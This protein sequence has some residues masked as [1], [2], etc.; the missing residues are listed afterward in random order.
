MPHYED[1]TP[2]QLGD[3]V[4]GKPYNTPYEVVGPV[5]S[6]TPDVEAC[7]CQVAFA[8]AD[9]TKPG[10]ILIRTVTDYGETRAF[11]KVYP[12]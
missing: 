2:A 8:V 3:I 6:I 9:T 11:K 7:N 1:G 4:Q 12:T 5:V 10:A